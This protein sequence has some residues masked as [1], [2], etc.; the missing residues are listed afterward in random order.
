MD[1]AQI[2]KMTSVSCHS[3]K[4]S[5]GTT[6]L[7]KQLNNI[8]SEHKVFPRLQ[9]FIVRKLRGIQTFFLNVTE[10]KKFFY[11]TLVHFNMCTFCIPRSFL[12]IN[13]CN[14]GKTLRAHAHTHTQMCLRW[15]NNPIR[16]LMLRK[17]P[18]TVFLLRKIQDAERNWWNENTAA[19]KVKCRTAEFLNK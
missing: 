8:Q 18:N 14:Q 11:N 3:H 4:K 12:V 15:N 16:I 6:V 7:R 17:M 10:L 2:K 9:T 5:N 1:K 13:V 19:D